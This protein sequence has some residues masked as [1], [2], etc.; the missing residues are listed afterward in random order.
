MLFFTNAEIILSLVTFF[1]VLL[2]TKKIWKRGKLPP[3][4][5]GMPILGNILQIGELPHM[6]FLKMKEKYGDVFHLKLGIVPVVVVSGLETIKKVLLKQG[7]QFASRPKLYTFSLIND[8]TSLAFSEQFGD[9]WKLHKKIA[10]M[11]LKEFSKSSRSSSSFSIF[12][13]FMSSQS[14]ALVETLLKNSEKGY[15]DPSQDITYTAASV[16]CALCYGKHYSHDDEEFLGI[17][18]LTEVAQK[19]S[20]SAAP[21][22]FIPILRFFPLSGVRTLL[23]AIDKFNNFTKKHVEEHFE[24]YEK[25]HIRDITDALIYLCNRKKVEDK[26][27]TLSDAQIVSTVNDMFGAGYDTISS[28]V[29]WS[30]LYLIKYPEVQEKIHKEIDTLIGAGRFPRFDDRHNLHFTEAFIHEVFRHS[31]F[32]PFT[33]PH[34]TTTDAVLNGYFIPK[35]T[36]I[37]VNLYQVHHDPAL[38][39]DPDCFKPERFLDKEGKVDKHIAQNVIIFGMGIRKCL[40]EEVSRNELFLMLTIIL[41]RLRLEKRPSDELT[42]TAINGM[43][44]KP[45][46]YVLKALAR[47]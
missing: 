2:I 33:I 4:P 23:R 22:D 13:E 1:I 44:L 19:E 14:E 37:L 15:F 43:A 24:S 17:I 29:Q 11:S 31:S 6:T 38:W 12:E 8:G 20:G 26:L 36:C 35:N 9:A 42:A 30:F 16:I 40:G 21:A 34:C 10:K 7:E 28:A 32:S 25:G 46:K 47:Y 3:G 18:K 41:Q 39:E 27:F 5:W 45:K